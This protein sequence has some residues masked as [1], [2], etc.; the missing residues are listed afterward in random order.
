MAHDRVDDLLPHLHR[1]LD[2][3]GVDLAVADRF[4]PF[5]LAV[6]ADDDNL[7]CLP[8]LLEGSDGAERRRIVDG[9]DAAEIAVGLKGILGRLIA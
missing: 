8:C 5:G 4:L 9:E 6:K 3:V 1:E 2:R 7:R